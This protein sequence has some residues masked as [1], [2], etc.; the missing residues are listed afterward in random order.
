M[1]DIKLTERLTSRMR[2]ECPER[3]WHFATALDPF[4]GREG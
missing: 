2:A 4:W 1:S 3:F